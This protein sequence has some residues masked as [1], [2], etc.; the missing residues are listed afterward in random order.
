M[1]VLVHRGDVEAH[2]AEGLVDRGGRKAE[3]E[4]DAKVLLVAVGAGRVEVGM[5]EAA[6]AVQV[7]ALTVDLVEAP[8]HE[9]REPSFLE[10]VRRSPW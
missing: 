10:Q 3:L 2:A 5:I 8:H 4:D 6:E 9:M 7:Q 1:I